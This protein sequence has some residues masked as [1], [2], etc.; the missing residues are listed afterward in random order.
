[1]HWL[2]TEPK[3]YHAL[4]TAMSVGKINIRKKQRKQM[5]GL[6]SKKGSTKT[7]IRLEVAKLIGCFDKFQ[8]G[9]G[10]VTAMKRAGDELGMTVEG[11]IEWK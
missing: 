5:K 6:C 3:K 10:M 8:V 7:S 2:L 1:V 4:S 11:V 9:D